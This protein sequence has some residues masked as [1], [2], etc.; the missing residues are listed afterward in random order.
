MISFS[1]Q[2]LYCLGAI[3]EDGEATQKGLLFGE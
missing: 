3:N 2:L 1:M